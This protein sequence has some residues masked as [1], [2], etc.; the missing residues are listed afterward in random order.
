MSSS[1]LDALDGLFEIELV[2]WKK[3]ILLASGRDVYVYSSL[4]ADTI[5]MAYL[6]CALRS[7]TMSG[8]R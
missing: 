5:N 1:S 7:K 6:F 3:A 2:Q 8:S 4:L